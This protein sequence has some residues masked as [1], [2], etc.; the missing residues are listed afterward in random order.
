MLLLAQR[1][2]R[3][4]RTVCLLL[5]KILQ[6][7][8]LIEDVSSRSDDWDFARQ[9]RQRAAVEVPREGRVHDASHP[10]RIRA[11]G[12]GAGRQGERQRVEV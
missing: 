5:E 8:F 1:W 3:W 9:C 4:R 6:D 2:R 11:N 7:V 12:G 10:N